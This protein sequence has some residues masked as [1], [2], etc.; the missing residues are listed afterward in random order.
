MKRLLQFWASRASVIEN[1]RPV[2]ASETMGLII[3]YCRAPGHA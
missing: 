1:L 3:A 2:V